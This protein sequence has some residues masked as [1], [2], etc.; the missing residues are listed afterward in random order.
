MPKLT[1]GQKLA[2]L[3]CEVLTITTKPKPLFTQAALVAEL[4][5]L[6]I[7]R[8]STYPTIVPLLLSRG[9]VTEKAPTK[10][11]KAPSAGL[12]VLIP[13]PVAFDLADFLVKAF[14]GLVD[15]TFTSSLEASLD[16]IETGKLPRLQVVTE[17]W[18]TFEQELLAAKTLQPQRP[19]RKDLGPC[20]KCLSEGRPGHLR[21]IQGQKDDKPYEFAACDQD[22]KTQRICG[23]TAPTE[24]GSLI[25]A[26]PCPSCG[27][28]LRPVRR[29]DG[30]H[31]W[32][33]STCKDS[34][35][36]LADRAWQIVKSPLCRKCAKPMSH[37]ERAAHKGEFFWACFPC[38]AFSD[39]DVF[40]AFS[41]S[42]RGPHP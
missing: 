37:R 18:H 9:W 30:G 13:E 29:R 19:E 21:L 1:R 26:L 35:W 2:V 31:S 28:Q 6:G 33:C 17:W 8:P 16:D 20:P 11:S 36:F 38:N 41:T 7:G 22:T 40:G 5:R 24:K 4:K 32:I 39:S 27:A 14:P 15:S 12:S 42:A 3:A 23:F 34:K 25:E 10:K